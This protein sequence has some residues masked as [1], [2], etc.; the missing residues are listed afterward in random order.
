MDLA[1]LVI[2][3]QFAS[4]TAATASL[5]AL[6]AA[7][8]RVEGS[9]Y[10]LGAVASKAGSALAAF[11]GAMAGGQLIKTIAQLDS[12]SRSFTV[13]TGSVI[14]SEKELRWLARTVDQL[15]V[16]Y[17]TAAEAYAGL[18]A[19]AKGTSLEGQGARDI[20]YAVS[21][22]MSVLGRSA[23]Q[24]RGALLSL[25]QMISK[26]QVQAEELRGQLGERLPGAFA[27]AAKAMGVTTERLSKMLELGLVRAEVLLPRL[28]E[29][30]NALYGTSQRADTL[31]AS[32]NRLEN[33]FTMIFQEIGRLGG[34]NLKMVIDY[35]TEIVKSSDTAIIA[36]RA[37]KNELSK[38]IVN[39]LPNGGSG[40]VGAI[41]GQ[42][43]SGIQGP[44][45]SIRELDQFIK[46][47][48]AAESVLNILWH[49]FGVIVTAAID[50]AV[51]D[52]LKLIQ[53]FINGVVGAVNYVIGRLNALDQFMGLRGDM[54]T[55]DPV[56]LV[57]ESTK[58]NAQEQA[59]NLGAIMRGEIER[60][61]AQPGILD[62][63][64]KQV[65]SEMQTLTA[66]QRV[67]RARG[68]GG[69]G[70]M[71]SWQ[72][73][74]APTISAAPA[75]TST[76]LNEW[77]REIDQIQDQTDALKQQ[78]ATYGMAEDAA[79]RYTATKRLEY[80]AK[81]A[82]LKITPAM[83]LE[84]EREANAY[85][86]A[87]RELMM[88]KQ[89]V[90]NLDNARSLAQG[91]LSSFKEDMM[92]GTGWV[93]SFA[94]ALDRL[95]DKLFE[96]AE[97]QFW[98]LM[99]GKTGTTNTGLLGGL[100]QGLLGGTTNTAALSNTGSKFA[101]GGMVR[102]PGTGTSD[103]IA[104]RLSHGEFVVNASAT[105]RNRGALEAI[106][107]GRRFA[108]GG[109]AGDNDNRPGVNVE[110]N[111]HGMPEGVQVDKSRTRVSQG[112]GGNVRVDA[113]VRKIVR[114]EVGGDFEE[115]GPL[116]NKLEQV[117]NVRRTKGGR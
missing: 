9:V 29:E 21:N 86:A 106:N 68:G 109:Y 63:F 15:G 4:V 12:L 62:Q 44:E 42:G 84:I 41:L 32:L 114:E 35:L 46:A 115:R 116:F 103:S 96:L 14:N 54:P 5:N 87:T 39:L 49:N 82:N 38:E 107:S 23:D 73:P 22:A 7:S 77:Q 8:G 113:F 80:A 64:F 95:G 90:E 81:E 79:A 91:S 93:Q 105:R 65:D 40:G 47:M 78:A 13:I 33:A 18:A 67:I 75:K 94:N 61:M 36:V 70:E 50:H 57:D 69:H 92:E 17:Q 45:Q 60:Q 102:G 25:Q 97:N 72:D 51:Q 16:E 2:N 89:A 53:D 48:K 111:L 110:I 101:A 83:R 43:L 28:A 20:F 31:G 10:K 34:D 108:R 6:G 99:I 52:S 88:M 58:T 59:A 24:T 117:S 112:A 3:V 66:R 11:I 74:V 71:M 76:K 104:A 55:M 27:A 30:L 56:K 98:D 26:G 37:L 85:A 1:T 100:F 19:S